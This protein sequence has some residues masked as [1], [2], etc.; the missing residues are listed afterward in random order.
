MNALSTQALFGIPLVAASWAEVREHIQHV[1]GQGGKELWITANPEIVECAFED[2]ALFNILQ[3]K[4]VVFPDGIGLI[5]AAKLL[6][7]PLTER[8][9]GIDMIPLFKGQR[10]YLLG[11]RPSV[12][13]KAAENLKTMGVD[14]VGFF[15]GYFDATEEQHIL[16]DLKKCKPQVLLVG[17]G[18][19]RQERWLAENFDQLPVNIAVTVGGSFDVISG[20]KKRAPLF[21]QQIHLEWLY[22]LLQ[23]PQRIWRQRKLLR[24]MV[25]VL[26]QKLRITNS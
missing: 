12:I 21:I 20:A 13:K 26:I 7:L 24:F 1:I 4:A 15:H 11:A 5:I 16:D 6:H 3:K 17:L 2:P 25:R 23:E 22:R 8:L 9:S 14:V 19:G 18:L 10:V